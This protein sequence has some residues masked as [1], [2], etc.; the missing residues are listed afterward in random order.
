MDL[1]PNLIFQVRENKKKNRYSGCNGLFSKD[2]Y[3]NIFE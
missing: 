1:F 2:E 3:F